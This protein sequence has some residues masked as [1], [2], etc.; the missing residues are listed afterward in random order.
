M[1]S[2]E[3]L[4]ICSMVNSSQEST[5]TLARRFCYLRGTG[6]T[7]T[8]ACTILSFGVPSLFNACQCMNPVRSGLLAGVRECCSNCSEKH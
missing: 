8:D 5:E 6:L 4:S 1:S 2:G 3:S 7:E